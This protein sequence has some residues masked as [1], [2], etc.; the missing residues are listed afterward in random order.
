MLEHSSGVPGVIRVGRS[1]R[2]D[3]SETERVLELETIRTK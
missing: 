2:L 1:W 3:I